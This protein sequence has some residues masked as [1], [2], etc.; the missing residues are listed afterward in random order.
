MEKEV[1]GLFSQEKEELGRIKTE[2]ILRE[3]RRMETYNILE[4]Y[5]EL[6]VSRIQLLNLHTD[7]PEELK[8][9]VFSL[10]WACIRADIPELRQVAFQFKLKYSDDFVRAAFQ[11]TSCCVN[12]KLLENLS[13]CSLDRELI[14]EEVFRLSPAL[15][16]NLKQDL[17]TLS[18]SERPL[19]SISSSAPPANYP[20]TATDAIPAEGP[21]F[22]SQF[23]PS[24]PFFSPPA[25]LPHQP[26][27]LPTFP[28]PSLTTP[29]TH[30]SS[31]AP[32]V[33]T[34][35]HTKNPLPQSSR[36][37]APPTLP[38]YV[39]LELDFGDWSS[40]LTNTTFPHVPI[41]SNLDT[42]PSVRPAASFQIPSSPNP[43]PA[44][45]CSHPANEEFE[46]L[47]ARFDA[48]R[49]CH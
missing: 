15:K 24:N 37:Q 35:Q 16:Q 21:P 1:A 33:N 8:E 38:Q 32:P 10:L 45:G 28:N 4:F 19:A 44:G 7:I 2:Q 23:N 42:H 11:N 6:L 43:S 26:S 17:N 31:V 5:C 47:S 20:Y 49:N 14:E 30:S 18:K 39:P 36:P 29:S 46:E 25:C 48:L 40:P 27:P 13:P 3:K 41:T 22:Y 9:S 34:Y 12:E